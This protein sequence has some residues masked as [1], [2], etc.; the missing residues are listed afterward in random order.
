VVAGAYLVLALAEWDAGRLTTGLALAREA[1][2]RAGLT[3]PAGVHPRVLLAMMLTD[4]HRHDEARAVLAGAGDEAR[5]PLT[6]AAAPAV[7]CA[8]AHLAAGRFAEAADEAR[9]ALAAAGATGPHVLVSS[10]SS[11]LATA[12]LR[13]GDVAAARRYAVA[14]GD[15]PGRG[16]GQAALVLVRAQ[17]EEAAAGPDGL[18]ETFGELCAQILRHRWTLVADPAAAAWLVRTARELDAGPAAEAVAAAAE[19]IAADDPGLPAASAAAAHA[20]GLLAGSAALLQRAAA[21]HPDPWARASAT[22]DLGRLTGAADHPDA[23][24]RAV[25]ALDHALAAY[26]AMGARRDAA[27]VRRRLRCLG[28]RR[29]HWRH[30]DRPVSGWASLTDTERAVSELVAQGLTNRQVADQLFMSAHTVAFHLRHV[31]RKLDIGSR[32]ELTRLTLQRT[33]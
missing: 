21:G 27:R 3:R 32:V 5:A 10:A 4:A 6:W 23:R 33:A 2:H 1:V 24:R 14:S 8:R 12:A 11:V 19:R 22:E 30:T 20:C 26:E 28:V 31:F 25:D 15:P 18:R 17:A 29:R 7:L 16:Y 9:A 13:T